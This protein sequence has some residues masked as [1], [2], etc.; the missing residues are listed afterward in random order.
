[1]RWTEYSRLSYGPSKIT[2]ILKSRDFFSVVFEEDMT[3]EKK[4]ETCNFTGFG[5]REKLS[6]T[7]ECRHPLETGKC[8]ETHSPRAPVGTQPCRVSLNFPYA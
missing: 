5:D 1:M 2:W 8:K 7:K 3:M 4:S 6:K